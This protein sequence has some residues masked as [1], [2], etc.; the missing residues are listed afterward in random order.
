M[1]TTTSV[2]RSASG[3]RARPSAITAIV[4][5]GE[6]PTSTIAVSVA[7]AAARSPTGQV[8]GNRQERPQEIERD[9][10]RQP[11]ADDRHGGETGHGG[12]TRPQAGAG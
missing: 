2:A 3:P 8:T 4:T 1:N 7:A 12:E 6:A 10:E 11:R 5:A 9:A